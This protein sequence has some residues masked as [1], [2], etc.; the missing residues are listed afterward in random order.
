MPDVFFMVILLSPAIAPDRRQYSPIRRIQQAI[1]MTVAIILAIA[2]L[3]W[4]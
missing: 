2:S 3:M 1:F 4:P